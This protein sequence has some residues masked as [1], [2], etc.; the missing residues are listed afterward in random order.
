MVELVGAK[1]DADRASAAAA[2]CSF[3][4][5]VVGVDAADG[6]ADDIGIA[7]GGASYES[8]LT[9]LAL[10]REGIRL[11]SYRDTRAH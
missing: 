4:G 1:T 8:P 5:D 6:T 2:V 10:D 7:D 9:V 11:W 3:T